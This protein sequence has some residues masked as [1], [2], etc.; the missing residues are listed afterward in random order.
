MVLVCQVVCL[1]CSLFF[2]FFI[3]G[4]MKMGDE[5]FQGWMGGKLVR[6]WLSLRRSVRKYP[7]MRTDAHPLEEVKPD[8]YEKRTD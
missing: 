7:N 6:A 4:C 5:E 2:A 8:V 3:V 1:L